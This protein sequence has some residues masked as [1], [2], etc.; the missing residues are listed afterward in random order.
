MFHEI[1]GGGGGGLYSGTVFCS[2]V[3]CFELEIRADVPIV[4]TAS[5]SS[6]IVVVLV[7]PNTNFMLEAM[8]CLIQ[9]YLHLLH[10]MPKLALQ[11][12]YRRSIKCSTNP[13]FMNIYFMNIYGGCC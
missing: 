2:S 10:Q 11:L 8:G 9:K 1:A 7:L 3:V 13:S 12:P 6:S 4:G 5:C